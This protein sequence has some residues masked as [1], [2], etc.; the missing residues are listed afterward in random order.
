MTLTAID[1]DL[2]IYNP[3]A[4]I[5]ANPESSQGVIEATIIAQREIGLFCPHCYQWGLEKD[6]TEQWAIVR[7][8][9][10]VENAD[11]LLSR[12][13]HFFHPSAPDKESDGKCIHWKAESD[14][15]SSAKKYIA[16]L[17]ERLSGV[18][19][20]DVDTLWLETEDGRKRKP[21]VLVTYQNGKRSAHEIQV[22]P[23]TLDLLMQRSQDIKDAGVDSI[24]WHLYGKNFNREL[25]S[26]LW[27]NGFKC[28]HLWF[29]DGERPQIKEAN[30]S[31]D[32]PLK[33]RSSGRDTCSRESVN[34]SQPKVAS[35]TTAIAV[36][37]PKSA[38]TTAKEKTFPVRHQRKPGWEGEIY[39]SPWNLPDH[40]DV[41]W[42][43][44]PLDE[45]GKRFPLPVDPIR[46]PIKD[47]I[48][49]VEDA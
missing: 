12:R 19:T 7:F 35:D 36:A 42:R 39:E 13:P 41:I 22:S 23:I 11:G 6:G 48:I 33:E 32:K 8:R 31:P 43:R 27:N 17:A 16:A 15:H 29:E 47:L 45:E 28:F 34:Y 20:V 37:K 9:K 21:D 38:R 2:K 44:S 10:G 25:R 4:E 5:S 26:Y 1:R 46:Y 30:E 40:L 49:E 18:E 24:T 3:A 14:H